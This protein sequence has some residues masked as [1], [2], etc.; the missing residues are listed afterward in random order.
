M[1]V[2]FKM[3]SD[4][5]DFLS[6]DHSIPGQNYVCLSFV[7]PEE[8]ILNKS[9]FFVSRF[10]KSVVGDFAFSEEPTLVELKAFKEQMSKLL[11]PETCDE[12]YK[13][14]LFSKQEELEKEYYEKNNYQTSIR[15]LKVR[16]VYDT[17]KE[18]QHRAKEIQRNDRSFN[19]YIGQV[20]YWLPWDPTPQKVANQEYLE[21][22]LNNLVKKYQ[23]NQK[24]KEQHFQENL[25]YV[26]EQAAKQAE[27]SRQEREKQSQEGQMK[28]I[29]DLLKNL[30]GNKQ[31][32]QSSIEVVEDKKSSDSLADS[33]GAQDPWMARHTEKKTD[34]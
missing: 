19:V 27:K 22:G 26:K 5:E 34:E 32:Q 10:L 17:L 2:L 1:F 3:S 29:D 25:D 18:A 12:K 13:D 6:V 16:G 21:E 9:S 30:S 4:K 7:S 15:G 20:G 24:F 11:S 23:E 33:L 8:V 28:E 31:E 14:Y